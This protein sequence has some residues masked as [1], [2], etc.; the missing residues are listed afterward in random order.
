MLPGFE[1]ICRSRIAS[2]SVAVISSQAI[3][4]KFY[5]VCQEL[6]A[7]SFRIVELGNC[8][9]R[10]I[11]NGLSAVLLNSS[12]NWNCLAKMVL[13]FSR[14]NFLTFSRSV[15]RLSALLRLNYTVFIAS[16]TALN[17]SRFRQAINLKNQHEFDLRH[18]ICMLE[19]VK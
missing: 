2:T 6:S 5:P 3:E 13:Y 1:M 18:D 17:Y 19:V 15:H 4:R 7:C 9:P 11:C 8:K 16:P 14:L 12:Q 10:S